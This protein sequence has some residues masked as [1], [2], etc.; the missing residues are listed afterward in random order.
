MIFFLRV[1]VCVYQQQILCWQC[2]KKDNEQIVSL[3]WKIMSPQAC[4]WQ[5]YFLRS[6]LSRSLSIDITC[7]L[8]RADADRCLRRW[9]KRSRD[10]RACWSRRRCRREWAFLPL[11]SSAGRSAVRRRQRKMWNIV[12]RSASRRNQRRRRS[13][14]VFA[15]GGGERQWWISPLLISV[16]HTLIPCS[17]ECQRIGKAREEEEEEEVFEDIDKKRRRREREGERKQR[18]G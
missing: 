4:N 11:S 3:S 17:N 5:W 6:S 7:S 12:R 9:N 13:W 10:G 15:S 8:Q 18:N 14:T 2:R 1:C 16:L